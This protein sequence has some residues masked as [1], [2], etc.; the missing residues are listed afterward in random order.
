MSFKNDAE[1]SCVNNECSIYLFDVTNDA[2]GAL[3]VHCSITGTTATCTGR[4]F[5]LFF[6]FFC[7]FFW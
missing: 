1:L 3:F 6:F 7:L 2:G 5:F 4:V